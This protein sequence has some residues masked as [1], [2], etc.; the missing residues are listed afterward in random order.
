MRPP[1]QL[2]I[3]VSAVASSALVCTSTKTADI[4][5]FIV[6]VEHA[7]DMGRAQPEWCG[8]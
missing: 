3:M 6:A 7:A 8:Y 1:M 4:I 2:E 5:S